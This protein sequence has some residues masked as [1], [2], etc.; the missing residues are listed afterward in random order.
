MHPDYEIEADDVGVCLWLVLHVNNIVVGVGPLGPWS[1]TNFGKKLMKYRPLEAV[2]W[3]PDIKSGCMAD[4][5][6]RGAKTKA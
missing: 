3:P 6:G 2:G 4:F 1:A 5:E